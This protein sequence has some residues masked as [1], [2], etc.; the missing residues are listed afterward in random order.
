MKG[1]LTQTHR[2]QLAGCYRS[3]LDLAR[4]RGLD[5]VAFCCISTGVYGF[6]RKEAAAIAV[7][8]VLEGLDR[9]PEIER[10][11]FNVFEEKDYDI[12]RRLL[13]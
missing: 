4:D 10:V 13:A 11:I 12:Y 9:A 6:P 2:E 1:P 3:C 7:E 8:T 5:S